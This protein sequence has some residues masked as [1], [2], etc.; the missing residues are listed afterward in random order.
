[1]PTTTELADP[2]GAGFNDAIDPQSA[3]TYE[4]G[5][6]ADWPDRPHA[7]LAL[8]LIELDNALVPF[9]QHGRTFFRN[10][11]RSRRAGLELD[12]T[13]P[14]GRWLR[15]TGALTAIDAEYRD[16]PTDAGTFDGNDEPGIPPWQLYQEL[17]YRHPSGWF[18]AC[19]AL[20]VGAYPAD[21]ANTAQ[22]DVYARLG[23]RAAYAHTVGAWTVAPFVALDNLLDDH[24]DAT[25]RLNAAGARYFEP[26]AGLTVAGASA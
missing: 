20:V 5:A 8:F 18:A 9:E 26:A 15:W 19:E 22:T 6:R 16:Y 23:V 12:A 17:A 7:G 24:Y 2:D 10:A 14:L 4:L 13:V 11:G 21:D 25:V 3:V 1:M